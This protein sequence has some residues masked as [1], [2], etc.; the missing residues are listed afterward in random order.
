M[1]TEVDIS[2]LLQL[3]LSMYVLCM[4]SGLRYRGCKGQVA[5]AAGYWRLQ[6][7]IGTHQLT[8][9]LLI[10]KA[11]SQDCAR[12]VLLKAELATNAENNNGVIAGLTK[13]SKYIAQHATL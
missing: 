1:H 5:R 6:Q 4:Q 2:C 9:T 12:Q 11:T 7:H 10:T 8:S 13:L 3:M